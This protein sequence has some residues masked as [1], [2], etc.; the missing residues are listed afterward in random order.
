[1]IPELDELKVLLA[2]VYLVRTFRLHPT[3]LALVSVN[4]VGI[5]ARQPHEG[6]LLADRLQ[7]HNNSITKLLKGNSDS[8]NH[9]LALISVI[10]VV[11]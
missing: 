3:R 11:K 8:I 5:V 6:P 7:H 10:E 4:R 1:M 9:C 2:L